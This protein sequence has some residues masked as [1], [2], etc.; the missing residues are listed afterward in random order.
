MHMDMYVEM[1]KKG[2]KTK[3]REEE[4]GRE[5]GGG[6]CSIFFLFSPLNKIFSSLSPV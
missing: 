2:E 3:W 5:G 6:G 1:G 4:G